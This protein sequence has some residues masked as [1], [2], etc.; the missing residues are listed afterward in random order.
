MKKKIGL[1]TWVSLIIISVVL[2]YHLYD[3][4]IQEIYQME[5]GQDDFCRE[6]GYNKSTDSFYKNCRYGG[7]EWKIE[8]DGNRIF[9]AYDIDWCIRSDKWGE[10]EEKAPTYYLYEGNVIC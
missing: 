2:M 5:K 10:C 1:I 4:G 9:L 6:M 8:C 7:E 3:W